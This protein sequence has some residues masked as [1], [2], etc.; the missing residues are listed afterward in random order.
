MGISREENNKSISTY[1]LLLEIAS[2]LKELGDGKNLAKLIKDAYA[3]P[4][5][6]QAKAEEARAAISANQKAIDDN[7]AL[8]LTIDSKQ[9]KLDDDIAKKNDLLRAIKLESAELDKK[10]KDLAASADALSAEKQAIQI[11]ETALEAG[12]AKLE[13]DR[14]SLEK[15]QEAFANEQ[16]ALKTTAEQ[17]K[18]LVG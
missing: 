4:E 11:R 5:K 12:I 17:I 9:A 13:K 18:K 16:A 8:L 15:D 10:K 3:L 2:A 7:A 14:I 1:Q 6:E